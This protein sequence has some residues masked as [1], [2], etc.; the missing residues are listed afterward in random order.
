MANDKIIALT[1]TS[2]RPAS[3]SSGYVMLIVLLLAI[4]ADVYGDQRASAN[5][6]QTLE[7]G[8]R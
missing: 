3:T 2:E 7:P 5:A 8:H 6:W 1:A 4:L